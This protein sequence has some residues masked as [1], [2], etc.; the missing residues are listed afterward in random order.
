MSNK[1]E[2]FLSNTSNCDQPRISNHISPNLKYF[3][4]SNYKDYFASNTS[5]TYD[6]SDLEKRISIQEKITKVLISRLEI[7]DNRISELNSNSK[8][9][10]F[11]ENEGKLKNDFD[12]QNSNQKYDNSINQIML[13]MN[14]FE[15]ELRQYKFINGLENRSYY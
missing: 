11:N 2:G 5:K 9:I 8:E 13:R 1:N 12:I 6:T 7:I 15:N 3:Q 10:Q 14:Q 4:T